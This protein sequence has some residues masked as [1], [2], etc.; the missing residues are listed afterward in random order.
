MPFITI[1]KMK[2]EFESSDVYSAPT[3]HMSWL[4]PPLLSGWARSGN[5]V[6][7][8]QTLRNPT[9]IILGYRDGDIHLIEKRVVRRDGD[10]FGPKTG[11]YCRF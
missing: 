9:S 7:Q 2:I 8:S 11:W 4:V 3:V 6:D 1:D 10:V 5:N